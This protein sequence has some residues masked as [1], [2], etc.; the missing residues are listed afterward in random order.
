MCGSRYWAVLTTAARPGSRA[1]SPR[2]SDRMVKITRTGDALSC[3]STVVI[4]STKRRDSSTRVA[5][6]FFELIDQE[7]QPFLLHAGQVRDNL[8][9]IGTRPIEAQTQLV[10]ARGWRR[11]APHFGA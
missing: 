6:Q 1:H 9:E 11:P 2:N 8:R 4:R 10:D 3:F 7:T 5:E